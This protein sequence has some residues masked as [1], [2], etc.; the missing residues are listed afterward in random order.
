ME[1]RKRF[2]MFFWGGLCW[3]MVCI[4]LIMKWYTGLIPDLGRFSRSGNVNYPVFSPEVPTHRGGWWVT[5]HVA[6]D[7]MLTEQ[8]SWTA[9]ITC[10]SEGLPDGS[11]EKNPALSMQELPVWAWSQKIPWEGN[12]TRSPSILLGNAH[13]QKKPGGLESTRC[14]GAGHQLGTSN[15]STCSRSIVL[16]TWYCIRWVDFSHFLWSFQQLS[17]Y[18]YKFTISYSSCHW[19]QGWMCFW[20]WENPDSFCKCFGHDMCANSSS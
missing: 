16:C 15:N 20:Q 5:V 19:N 11:V 4:W 10:S 18:S 3:L 6:K 7:D 1:K 8:R 17:L 2:Y 12:L 9:A 14:P 13:G